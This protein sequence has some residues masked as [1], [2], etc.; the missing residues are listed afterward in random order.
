MDIRKL[1]VN[2]R[3]I[4]FYKIL[5]LNLSDCSSVLDV[6]CGSNSPI[7]A[8]KKMPY[9][10]GI[11]IYRQSII[12]SKKNKI[13]DKYKIG[14]IQ[15]LEKYYKNKSFDAV[16]AMDV[17]E[18]FEKKD[19]LELLKK[20]EKIARKKVIVL[21]PNGFLDQGHYDNNPHQDH[22]SG[23]S[24]QDLRS[25]GYKVYGLRSFKF[26]RGEFTS[27]RFKPWLFWGSLAFVTEPILYYFP[28]FSFHIF[29][30]K[31]ISNKINL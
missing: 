30:I 4:F 9:S 1:V 19:A 16:I 2:F 14:N 24:A 29:A 23:W 26:L 13:H 8:I 20:M 25:L 31:I 28:E 6:G 5:E 22:K 18:H 21:T 3:D 12:D 7:K 15:N 11:D 27:I 17:I 10:E